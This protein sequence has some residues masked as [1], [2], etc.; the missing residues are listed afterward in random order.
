MSKCIKADKHHREG[1][2]N[3]AQTSG[4]TEAAM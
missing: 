4:P 1:A 3:D 2:Y